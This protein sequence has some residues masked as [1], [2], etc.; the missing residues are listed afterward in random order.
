V[1]DAFDRFL[2]RAFDMRMSLLLCK[3]LILMFFVGFLLL[4]DFYFYGD[5]MIETIISLF[6]SVWCFLIPGLTFACVE[7]PKGEYSIM[8]LFCLGFCTRLR[9]RC[10]DFLHLLLIDWFLRGFLLHDLCAFLGNIDVVF[11]SVDR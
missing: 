4:F 5:V 1:G 10:A 2:T 3:Q 9:L 6:Y 8:L 7:H 11:G